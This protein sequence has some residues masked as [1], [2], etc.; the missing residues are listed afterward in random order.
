[1]QRREVLGTL[2]AVA[3]VAMRAGDARAE[4]KPV[5]QAPTPGRHQ[6]VPLPFDPKKIKGLSDKLL[7]SHHDNNYAGAVKNLNAVEAQIAALPKDA[8]AFVVAGLRERELTFA[9]SKVLHELYFGNLGGDGKVSGSLGTA[10]ANAFGSLGTF[11]SQLHATAMAL[12]GGSGWATLQY[13]L[14]LGE[15]RIVGSGGHVQTLAAGVPLLVLDMYEHAFALDYGAAAAKYLDAFFQ[16]VQWDEVAR[17]YDKALA[18]H[19]ALRG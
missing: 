14:H 19:K 5:V 13:S 17:R 15:L 7:T 6:V 9:N 18:A 12:A 8:P 1:M 2:A 3:A 16:T 10:L 4:D 11:E